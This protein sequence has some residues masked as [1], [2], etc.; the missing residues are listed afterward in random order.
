MGKP[1]ISA[2]EY[3]EISASVILKFAS[4]SKRFGP[5]L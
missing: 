4:S 1:I 5:N 2:S 3:A